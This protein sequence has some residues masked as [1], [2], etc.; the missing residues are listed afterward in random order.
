MT[1]KENNSVIWIGFDLLI[2]TSKDSRFNS[3]ILFSISLIYMP[4]A[5]FL[6]VPYYLEDNQITASKYN[7]IPRTI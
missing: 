4:I 7:F 5:R 3:T 2:I 6:V 1:L